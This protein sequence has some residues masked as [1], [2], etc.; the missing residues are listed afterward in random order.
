MKDK[1]DVN[2]DVISNP[3][4]SCLIYFAPK[5]QCDKHGEVVNT[6]TIDCESVFCAKCVNELLRKNIGALNEI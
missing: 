5:Y 2:N 4:D 3:E 1:D 6:V